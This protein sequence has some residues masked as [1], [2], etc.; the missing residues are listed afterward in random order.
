MASPLLGCV[1]LREGGPSLSASAFV[2]R[3]MKSFKYPTQTLSSALTACVIKPHSRTVNARFEHSSFDDAEILT[4]F[5]IRI[6]RVV[7]T[8]EGG[9]DP[10]VPRS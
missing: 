8:W 2:E 3:Q 10:C 5:S 7:H 4:K 6:G 9:V 1:G